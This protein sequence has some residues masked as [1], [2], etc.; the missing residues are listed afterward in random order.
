MI[1]DFHIVVVNQLKPSTLPYVEILLHEKGLQTL[2]ICVDGAM[3]S[4]QVV[5][6]DP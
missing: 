5:S 6:L 1:E 4:V 3:D 2:V